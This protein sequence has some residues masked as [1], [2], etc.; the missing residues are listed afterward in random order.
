MQD[1]PLGQVQVKI[2]NIR[3]GSKYF[4]SAANLIYF[5]SSLVTVTKRKRFIT[6]RPFA[7]VTKLFCP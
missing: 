5:V 2:T 7:N 1:A 3:L 6:V 4:P